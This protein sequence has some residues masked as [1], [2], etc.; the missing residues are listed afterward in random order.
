MRATLL[1]AVLAS[2]HGSDLR[3]GVGRSFGGG[4]SESTFE[5]KHKQGGSASSDVEEST[6][7]YVELGLQ[8]TPTSV[9]NVEGDS[10][11]WLDAF[12]GGC[13]QCGSSGGEDTPT[14]VNRLDKLERRVGEALGWEDLVLPGGGGLT[15]CG[16]AWYLIRKRA[17]GKDKE[18]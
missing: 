16:L 13:G 18:A 12:D 9:R 17:Q 1:I 14:M 15:T 11:P 3:L 5:D 2:C 10:L 7:G 8:L 6:I 4:S